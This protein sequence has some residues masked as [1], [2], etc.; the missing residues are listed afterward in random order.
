MQ[1]ARTHLCDMHQTSAA[2]AAASVAQN[3]AAPDAG[4]KNSAASVATDSA[5]AVSTTKNRRSNFTHLVVY[6]LD[7]MTHVPSYVLV[8]REVR[9]CNAI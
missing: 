7:C 2:A 1:K 3:T 9:R 6:T 8:P 4:A 5:T